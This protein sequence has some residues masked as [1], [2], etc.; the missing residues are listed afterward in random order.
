MLG[1][2]YLETHL[3]HPLGQPGQ[4]PAGADQ[5][6]TVL[7]RF[8]HQLLREL[9][10]LLERSSGSWFT[11][12][13][14]SCSMSLIVP[15]LLAENNLSRSS[16]P[17]YTVQWTLLD[18]RNCV[19]PGGR[20]GCRAGRIQLRCCWMLRGWWAIW[21]PTT[22]C[23]RFLRR[24]ESGCSQAVCSTICLPRGEG[25]PR[26]RRRSQRRCWCFRRWRGCR[27]VRRW[28]GSSATSGRLRPVWRWIMRGSTRRRWTSPR[29]PD[30]GLC[31]CR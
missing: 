12:D 19:W 20:S 16:Q 30:T 17:R 8:S 31:G 23:T 10:V 9:A 2:L 14:A 28:S 15:S 5:I 22:A 25:V 29:V 21:S 13:G 26:C 11:P 4:H 6:Q 7:V 1:D 3:E 27:I 18:R 24:S